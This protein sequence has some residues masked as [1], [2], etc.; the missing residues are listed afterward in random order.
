MNTEQ[1][2]VEAQQLYEV[3]KREVERYY[4]DETIDVSIVLFDPY[5]PKFLKD[6]AERVNTT[7]GSYVINKFLD[8][9]TD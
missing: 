1:S 6:L 8:R 2:K 3:Y 4:G 9:V 7:F 5:A